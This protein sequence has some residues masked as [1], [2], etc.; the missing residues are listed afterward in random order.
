MTS[1]SEQAREIRNAYQRAYRR[2]NPDKLKQYVARY[3]EKKAA[4][5]TPAQQAKDL[6]SQ[7]YTQR[8]ISER[9]GISL[10]TV[11]KYLNTE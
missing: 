2:R 8:E 7:G 4:Q 11:N 9:L 6:H 5:I 10:G 1:L 3:W